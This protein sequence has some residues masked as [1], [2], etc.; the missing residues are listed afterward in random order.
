MNVEAK[1][2]PPIYDPELVADAILFA[3]AHPRRTLFVGG[4]AKSRR[5]A[6]ITRRTCSIAS[7]PGCSGAASARIDPP[8]RATTTRCTS[9]A[10]RCTS[11]K[12][13]TAV[14][15]GCAY[16]TVVQRPKVAG[17]SPSVR[18]RWWSPRWRGAPRVDVISFI[19][20]E[21]FMTSRQHTGHEYSHSR[22]HEGE[23]AQ[24]DHDKGGH[25]G[26]HGNAGRS[27]CRRR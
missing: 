27:T 3:A 26:G 6:R 23:R 8:A 18:R 16:N 22:A 19:P 5:R 2:P 13:W 17:R 20:K 12:A 9:R 7:R 14:L 11:A 1:L 25:Q 24:Q 4:A 10:M 21:I 15:R